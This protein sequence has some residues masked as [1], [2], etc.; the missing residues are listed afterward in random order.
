MDVETDWHSDMM[1]FNSRAMRGLDASKSHEKSRQISFDLLRSKNACADQL[2]LFEKLGLD[3][4]PT[5]E[6]VCVENATNFDWLWAAKNLLSPAALEEFKAAIEPARV[7]FAKA[8]APA[9]AQYER[10]IAP[11]FTAYRA[12]IAPHQTTY[13]RA[14]LPA[15]ME[16]KRAIAHGNSGRERMGANAPG[17]PKISMAV[18]RGHGHE[19]SS[20]SLS[21][22]NQALA[23]YERAIAPA[24]SAY[25]N[26]IAPAK[27]AYESAIA[28]LSAQYKREIASAAA[29][30]ER[31]RA[32]EFFK[33]WSEYK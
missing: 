7:I 16:H 13:E 31:V 18:K 22:A 8:I 9:R 26:A 33:L 11:A 3:T 12:A 5:T 19:R 24:R 4:I 17:Q 14:I 30:Y 10:A 21:S 28:P 1:N 32:I 23:K 6:T 27:A 15:S 25:K 29:V 20:V 2:A